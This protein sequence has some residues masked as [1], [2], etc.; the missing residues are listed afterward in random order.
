MIGDFDS[1]YRAVSSR[2]ERFDGWFIVAVTSTGIYCR[3]SCPAV[4]P[5]RK[6][7]RF[8]PTAGAA[9]YAG[10]RAC[11]RC[12][13]DAV[14]GSPEWDVRAD[15]AAR[16]MRLISD[17]VVD[18]EGVSGLA[19]R[20]GY[21]ER[22]LHRLLV[23]EL[24]AG[25]L[26]LARTRR[27]H[28]A[29]LLL[30]STGLPIT[31]VAFAAGFS[32][33]RQ[34]NETVRAVFAATPGELR[35]AGRRG[36][37][38]EGMERGEIHLRLPYREPLDIGG[39]LDFLGAR[40]VPGIES[41]EGGVYRRTLRLPHGAG[42]V[43]LSAGE[44][45]IRCVLRLEDLRDL[46]A[47]VQ[48][49]RRLLDLDADPVAVDGAFAADPILGPL[50]AGRPGLRTPGGTDAEELAARAV[51]GQQVSVAG[52]RTLAGRLVRNCGDGLPVSLQDPAETLTH[53]FPEPAAIAEA[54]PDQS[55]LPGARHETLVSLAGSLERGEVLLDPGADRD[56][57][58]R[59]LL[60]LRGIGP[61]TASYVAMRALGEPDAFLPTD[62]GV[63]RA[64]AR[65]GH[66]GNPRGVEALAERWRPWRSYAV[67]H[68]WKSLGGAPKE[69]E[70]R[71][72]ETV[73]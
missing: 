30:E 8:Y 44:G 71:R 48:R 69:K 23:A 59:R 41:Y 38:S 16:A 12:L 49:C 19:G 64:L 33:I 13:P 50:V 5:K 73:A 2:D 63:R 54:G 46:G 70:A 27:A 61:W 45:R 58:R 62:L 21:T 72:E 39:L 26:A 55:G 4:T 10:F 3:P 36:G 28:T 17:G 32:S 24:G 51:L 1:R 42:T 18:R 14:P 15:A 6:N 68:L 34:F 25:P 37:V 60:S 22:H 66:P 35:R 11:K 29:R 52:A 47:A 40:A 7:V 9:Q 20:L 31:Q 53:L 57:A 65:L 67:Q 56:E 43:A